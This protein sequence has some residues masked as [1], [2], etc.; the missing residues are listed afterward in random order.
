MLGTSP[1]HGPALS[2]NPFSTELEPMK[3][4]LSILAPLVL[5][6]ACATGGTLVTDE[7]LASFVVG[8]TTEQEVR[9]ALG[10]PQG[11]GVGEGGRHLLTY[12]F[13]KAGFGTVDTKTVMFMFSPDGKLEQV[14]AGDS[15]V[16]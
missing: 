8:E 15:G 14:H 10:K 16:D 12:A 5:F 2:L 4:L 1:A 13:T 7:Q 11:W 9:E 6:S 3:A